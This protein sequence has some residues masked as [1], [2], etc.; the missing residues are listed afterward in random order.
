MAAVMLTD[1]EIG[2]MISE[3]KI[4]PPG[5]RRKLAPRVVQDTAHKRAIWEFRGEDGTHFAISIR[6]N[7][8]R[9]ANF[10]VILRVLLKDR[11]TWLHLRRYNGLHAVHRN[12]IEGTIVRGNHIHEATERY[13]ARGLA[14]DSYATR[15]RRFADYQ[16]ALDCLIRDCGFVESQARAQLEI[17]FG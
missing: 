17:Q 9:P 5:W 12:R 4:L 1:A 11:D 15:T 8:L 6:V 13:Q 3:R 14:P 16:G 7:R 10:S 2:R